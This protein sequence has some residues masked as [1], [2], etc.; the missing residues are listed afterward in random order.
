MA[1]SVNREDSNKSG[2]TVMFLEKQ[3]PSMVYA[4][5]KGCGQSVQYLNRCIVSLLHVIGPLPI[6]VDGYTF[7]G[8]NWQFNFCCVYSM[9][10]NSERKEFAP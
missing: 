1:A 3:S 8:S 10:I 9:E 7:R 6:K 4:S 5:S 2:H